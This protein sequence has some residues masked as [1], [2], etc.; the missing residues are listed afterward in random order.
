MQ[1]IKKE[2]SIWKHNL[3]QNYLLPFALLL[4]AGA[5]L[6][7]ISAFIFTAASS[8]YYEG[9]YALAWCVYAFCIAVAICLPD[10]ILF[11]PT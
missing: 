6:G 11:E 3:Y 4:G 9:P 8:N 2:Y 5:I 10:I 7:I 1:P